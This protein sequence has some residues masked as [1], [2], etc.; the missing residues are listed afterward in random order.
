MNTIKSPLK[1][2]VL[3]GTGKTGRR[4]AD[5]LLAHG[6][7]T[8]VGSRSAAPPFDWT[9]RSTWEP[10]LRG[11]EAVYVAYHPDIAVPGA[12]EAIAEFT[13]LA[14][15]KGVE[16]LV[17]LSG[18][19]ELEAQRAERVVQNG[20]IPWTILRCS[21]FS[22]N[23]SEGI[24]AK[25]IAQTEVALPVDAIPEPF[26]DADDIADVA[27]GA[28]TS[29]GHEGKLYELTGPGAITFEEA[30]GEIATA[31]GRSIRFTPITLDEYAA[32]MADAGLPSDIVGF[33][34]Y[35][36]SEVLDGRNSSTRAGVHEAL[37]REA[38]DFRSYARRT[39][40]AG[41]FGAVA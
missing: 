28:L 35:L 10:A 24:F 33:V 29:S 2:V 4:V 22:Q 16:R 15:R 38:T 5:R 31:S 20:E 36:F 9:E 14:A 19:G 17:L 25:Q 3:C 32:A 1:T 30:V 27:V 6:V 34:T 12:P 40:A 39:A 8:R 21:W 13:D 7:P 11:M 18:R 41:G 37:G 23:F 26:V